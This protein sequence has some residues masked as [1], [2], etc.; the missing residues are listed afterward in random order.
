MWS[1]APMPASFKG[2]FE[3]VRPKKYG[4]K[5]SVILIN[6]LAE[7]AESWYRNARFWGRFFDVHTPNL[8]AYE[9]EALHRRIRSGEPI[10]VEYL[11]EQL[12]TYV[13]QFIQRPPYHIVSS[14]LG[15]KVAI[16]FAVQYPDLVNRMVLL[17]PSGMGDVER[18]PLLDGVQRSD[19]SAVIRAVFHKPRK[20][21]RGLLNYYKRCFQ[22]RKWKLGLIRTVKGTNDH[23]VR[24][25][26]KYI[27]APTLLIGGKE[28][29]IIDHLEGERAAVEMQNGHWLSLP[30]CGH[31]PQ[32]EMAR[33]VNRLVVHFLTSP[34][35]SAHPSFVKLLLNKPSRVLT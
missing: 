26:M 22:S 20:A 18:L 3:R 16:E 12:H 28:D 13:D 27:Q 33:L 24:S 4:R 29:K 14:S 11:V 31:A 23:V 10:T 21:D 2:L 17:C 8:M 5:S 6:G 15:G 19:Y 32:I 25:R 34:K 7:Q 35:P 1:D 30:R 9:G